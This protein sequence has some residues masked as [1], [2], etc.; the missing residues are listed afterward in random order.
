MRYTFQNDFPKIEKVAKAS[1]KAFCAKCRRGDYYDDA[2]ND[3]Y[4]LATE[5]DFDE[6]RSDKEIFSYLKLRI[7]GKLLRK[8]HNETGARRKTAHERVELVDIQDKRKTHVD[9]AQNEIVQRVI[10]R[11]P[12]YKQAIICDFLTLGKQKPVAKKHHLTKGRI[13][14]IIKEFKQAVR[15]ADEYGFKVVLVPAH[16]LPLFVGLDDYDE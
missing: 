2:L 7:V 8:L 9:V 6:T 13:S 4:I 3:S 16:D 14:Q 10:K 1:A 12:F 5:I 11:F 15:F